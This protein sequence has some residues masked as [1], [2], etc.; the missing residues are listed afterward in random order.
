MFLPGRV[1]R[2]RRPCCRALVRWDWKGVLKAVGESTACPLSRSVRL[3]LNHRA[4]VITVK[5]RPGMIKIK[6]LSA[7][8]PPSRSLCA[9]RKLPAMSMAQAI[10][11]DINPLCQGERRIS[12]AHRGQKMNM[13]NRNQSW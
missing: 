9:T 1:L 8:V 5:T 6:V 12:T 13:G 4:W 11:P 10:A 2:W 3:S 7:T